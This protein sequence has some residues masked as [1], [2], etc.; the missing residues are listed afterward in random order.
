MDKLAIN[1]GTMAF[2]RTVHTVP[3][4]PPVYAGTEEL[5]LEIYRSRAWSFNGKYEREFDKLFAEYHDAAHC[6]FMV[7][8]TVTLQA[9]LK[10]VNA[11]AKK[12][13]SDEEIRSYRHRF[14]A[15]RT[16]RGSLCLIP[17]KESSAAGKGKSFRRQTASF[18][19]RPMQ[20]DQ[21]SFP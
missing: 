2:D 17:W 12:F 16:C 20:C 8:G 11:A 9:A 13:S 21:Y 19:G 18:R 4:W 7:N 14:R 5:L 1:G 6:I 15:C 3:G 10:A